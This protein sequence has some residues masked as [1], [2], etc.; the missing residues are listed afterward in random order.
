MAAAARHWSRRIGG[1][2]AARPHGAGRNGPPRRHGRDRA[3]LAASHAGGGQPNGQCRT[4]RTARDRR[5]RRSHAASRGARSANSDIGRVPDWM[6]KRTE[7]ALPPP[8]GRPS[9][10]LAISLVTIFST[11]PGR[12]ASSHSRSIGLSMSRTRPSS[13]LDGAS[14]G[15]INKAESASSE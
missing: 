12:F 15:R 10:N 2:G 1:R 9:V 7:A 5:R 4:E 14:S 8:Q 6:T 13:V 3:R 11:I